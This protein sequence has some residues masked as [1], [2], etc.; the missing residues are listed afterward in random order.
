MIH[1]IVIQSYS[2]KKKKETLQ[3]TKFSLK[4]VVKIHTSEI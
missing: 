4:K 1:D 3:N 2:E